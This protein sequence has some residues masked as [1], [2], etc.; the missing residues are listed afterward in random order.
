MEKLFVYGTLQDSHVQHSLLGREILG[1]TDCLQG[2]SINFVLLPPYPV[3]MPDDNGQVDGQ[4][5]DLSTNELEKLDDYEGE[6]YLRIRVW[7]ESGQEAWVYIGNPA[8][9]PDEI[10]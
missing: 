4:I 10:L 6:G 8:Y 2:Y 9:Y 5:L 7:L 3:A 1:Q